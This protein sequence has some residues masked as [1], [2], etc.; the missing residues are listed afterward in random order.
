[1]P[2]NNTNK[3]EFLVLAPNP[4]GGQWM[5]RQQIFSRIGI[6]HNVI[7]SNGPLHFHQRKSEHFSNSPWLEKSEKKDNITLSKS[8][9][10][11]PYRDK[12]NSIYENISGKL[13]TH[14]I[15]KHFSAPQNK[16]LYI[17]HPNFYPLKK[18]ITNNLTIYHCYDDYSKQ[19]YYTSKIESYEVKLCHEADIIFA[20]SKNIK[21]RLSHIS[22]RS[23]VIFLPNAVNYDF[24]AQPPTEE[25]SD[26]SK[27]PTPR[28]SYIGSINKKFDFELWNTLAETM[29]AVSFICIGPINNLDKHDQYLLRS[30]KEKKNVHFL[31]EK[32][33]SEL[34]SYMHFMDI[35]TMAYRLDDTLWTDSI[36]PLKLHEYLAVGKPI[37]SANI[38]SITEFKNVIDVANTH[39][40]WQ[41]KISNAIQKG[42][43]NLDVVAKRKIA[44]DNTWDKCIERI[45]HIIDKHSRQLD[46][47]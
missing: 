15:H 22:G 14:S 34:A 37:I 1:M 25:P 33:H 20:S 19:D 7:Y 27:I 40:E 47:H 41:E 11:V 46:S 32:H 4:W 39:N 45:L 6:Q 18:H 30:L 29:T 36:Y 12:E 3:Y 43:S 38:D 5:N 26:L 31:P 44:K 8:P 28:V 23:D 21:K 2:K 17:F 42:V 13:F 24:F 10:L 16:I 35:N 9:K